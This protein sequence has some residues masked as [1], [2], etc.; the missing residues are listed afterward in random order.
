MPIAASRHN[1]SAATGWYNEYHYKE[2]SMNVTDPNLSPST[3]PSPNPSLTPPGDG[4]DMTPAGSTVPELPSG[5][6]KAGD[7]TV[8]R[9][10]FP[11]LISFGAGLLAMAL[12]IAGF[13]LFKAPAGGAGTAGGVSQAKDANDTCSTT[14]SVVASVNQWGSLAKELGGSCVEVTSLINSTSA[15]PH[16]YE[17][18]AADMAKLLAADIVIVNGAGYDGW[19][20][21]AQFGK[22]QNIINIGDL[23]GITVTEEH[24]HE[25]HEENGHHH[26]G[27]TNPHLWFSPEAVLKASGSIV[28]AY[29][30]TAGKRSDTA[31]TVQRHANA[32]NADY[33][34]FVAL[35][36]KARSEGIQRR[37]VA[38]ES[39]I[40][41]LLEYVGA[42]DNTPA[43]YTKSMNSEA[44]PT[45]ADL[46]EAMAQVSSDTTDLL[47]VNPQ[48]MSGFAEKLDDAAKNSDKTI[49]SV[50]EQLPERHD[51]L[52]AW[53]T[54]ITHQVL[55]ND[56]YNGWFLTQEVK[57]RSLADYANEWQSVY[58]LLKDGSLK[59]VME[60]KAKTGDMTVDEYT[61]YYDKGYAS[62][63]DSITITGDS[64]TF[65]RGSASV[66]ATYEYSGYR[67]LD[68]AKG[69]RGVRY[70]F[71]ASGDLPKGAPKA[72]QFSDHGISAGK[73]AHFHIFM[74]DS[75]EQ[76]IKEMDNWPTFYPASLNTEQVVEEMLAH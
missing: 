17:A 53:L 18:T 1:V 75:Q 36:N 20:A 37:Y 54:T 31:A 69:N 34:E 51:T 56:V 5:S 28:D 50:T 26:H 38:T 60:A 21:N 11:I 71:T 4:P 12:V 9:K 64:I 59:P 10:W 19:A 41:Y 45:A 47:I 22:E 8:L 70:L 48:A 14:I 67:I 72:V 63:V 55:A 23:M 32:W 62:D 76:A 29:Q 65:V 52:L 16:G 61:R 25:E 39:I 2:T 73:S 46:N 74:D 33:A 57:D 27:S 30:T 58:P 66:T 44:E 13:G 40:S 35:V 42:V 49:I 24:E 15:D 3:D 7:V 43:A 6:G 68:Y